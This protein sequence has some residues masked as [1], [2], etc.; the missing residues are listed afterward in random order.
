MHT[1]YSYS[2]IR[3]RL[4]ICCAVKIYGF[5]QPF[6]FGSRGWVIVMC[7]WTS[8]KTL[9]QSGY[10][11]SSLITCV[12]YYEIFWNAGNLCNPSPDMSF[13]ETVVVSGT[14]C[15]GS[16]FMA[17]P[18]LQRIHFDLC[19]STLVLCLLLVNLSRHSTQVA[20]MCVSGWLCLPWFYGEWRETHQHKRVAL[21]PCQVVKSCQN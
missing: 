5:I 4:S 10:V 18:R 6:G 2:A 17:L 20:R 9:F 21:Q 7:A 12:K 1:D 8:R 16:S 19:W 13:R 14:C 11:L 15:A 3:P